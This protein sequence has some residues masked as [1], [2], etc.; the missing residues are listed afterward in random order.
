ME[1]GSFN[2][3]LGVTRSSTEALGGKTVHH[4]AFFAMSS[5][6]FEIHSVPPDVTRTDLQHLDSPKLQEEVRRTLQ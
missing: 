2:E 3:Q 6:L 1:G 5:T 4:V